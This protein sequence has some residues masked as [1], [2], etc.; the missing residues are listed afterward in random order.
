[1]TSSIRALVGVA[2]P[3][4]LA[5]APARSTLVEDV[6]PDRPVDVVVCL[7]ASGSM[8]GLLTAVR[9][10]LWDV[11]NVIA[12]LEPQPQLRVG[13]VTYGA[14]AVGF[15][16]GWV[17]VDSPLT[18]DLDAFYGALDEVHP[19][20][21]EEY[22]GLALHTALEELEWSRESGAL[23]IIFVAGNESVDQGA[24]R[25]ELS[26]ALEAARQRGIIVN[27]LF[28]GNRTDGIETGWPRIATGGLGNF[29]AIDV[30]SALAQI[31]TPQDRALLEL[32]GALNRTYLPYGPGGADGLANQLAQDTGASRLGVQSCSSRIVAKGSALYDNGSWDLVDATLDPNFRWSALRPQDLPEELRAMDST[33]RMALIAAKRAERERIQKEIQALSAD[34]ERFLQAELGKLDADLGL[35]M[36][37]AIESQARAKG[38]DC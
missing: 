15:A 12:G 22:V 34:R 3:L 35:E 30:S 9:A 7:D 17:A 24:S 14:E 11:V 25:Y 18:D 36:R 26:V 27:A 2:G 21:G 4:L 20:G 6:K 19:K 32:N 29:S 5:A 16:A 33:A 10:R 28:A 38:F 31:A 13:L 8:E 1:M 37:R 23:Q